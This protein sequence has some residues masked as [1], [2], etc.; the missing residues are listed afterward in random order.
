MRHVPREGLNILLIVLGIFSAAMGLKGFLLSSNF[1][2]GGVTGVSMLLAKLTPWSLAIWLPVVNAPFIIVGYQ[3]MGRA[4]AVRSALAIGG[5][6]VVLAT[7]HFPDV[8]PDL[9]LT[10]IFGGF[11]IGAGIGLAVRGGAVLD[12]TEIAALLISKRSA[13]L[14]VGDVI[15]LFNI[16]LFLIAMRLLG[17]EPALYSILTYIAAAR[18]LDFV[19]YGLEEFTAIT[20]VSS[21][22]AAIRERITGVGLA[23]PWLEGGRRLGD[24]VAAEVE[25]F[26]KNVAA[27]DRRVD[28]SI[29][30]IEP[31]VVAAPALSKARAVSV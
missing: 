18:T 28:F 23:G 9:L 21:Q 17:V 2:D 24:R 25:A 31:E 7:V 12:G 10:A 16:A 29:M 20:I 13:L 6:A 3:H 15:L 27:E 8:T 22:S 26:F 11:F 1:I 14:K 30:S 19:I 5:L 4:F